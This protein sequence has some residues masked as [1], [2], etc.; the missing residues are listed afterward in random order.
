MAKDDLESIRKEINAL[1]DELL[2][3]I[4]KRLSLAP[5]IAK[6][7]KQMKLKV[8]QPKREEELLER[9]RQK[10]SAKG[11]DSKMIEKIFK[12]IMNESRKIQEGVD[13]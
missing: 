8:R 5:D 11:L 1:D 9:L 3:L 2:K 13:R 6:I 4:E 12:E 7:K 10:A